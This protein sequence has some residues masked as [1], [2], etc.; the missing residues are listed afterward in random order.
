M[1]G[2]YSVR[3]IR[4]KDGD[5]LIARTQSGRILE[6]RLS[7]I[8]APELSQLYG[9]QSMY[10]L[11][12]LTSGKELQFRYLETD[13]YQRLVGILYDDMEEPSVNRQMVAAGWAYYWPWYNKTDGLMDAAQKEARSMRKGMW[14]K[15]N[16]GIKPWVFREHQ[17]ISAGQQR[18][19][20]PRHTGQQPMP[21]PNTTRPVAP[22]HQE[23][24][25]KPSRIE[26]QH[27]P[28]GI[29]RKPD[30]KRGR[31]WNWLWWLVVPLI[32]ALLQA[33]NA[34]AR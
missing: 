12:R 9:R 19:P 29:Q 33:G 24:E 2:L 25:P 13:R 3:V 11:E 7:L 10:F 31:D 21:V 30:G 4:V 20:V 26:N 15:G 1:E 8:D 14:A 5:G 6:I 23:P 27:P 18:V 16:P 28:R 34:L 22:V 17:R 32:I